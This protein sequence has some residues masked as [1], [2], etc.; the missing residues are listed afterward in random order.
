[1][2]TDKKDNHWKKDFPV[3]QLEST[4]VSRRDFA[5]FL[6]LV[7]GGLAVGS[8][9]VAIKANFFPPDKIVGEHFVCKKH[10]LPVGGTRSFVIN[11]STIPYILIR[12]ENDEF[13][14]YEQKCTHLSC[15]VFYKPG[16]G[17]IECPCHNGLF[18][19]FT[20]EVLAGP[21]PRPLS[22][23]AVVIK[24]EEVYVKD[25]K[26]DNDNPETNRQFRS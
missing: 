17:K 19:A 21:P 8:G 11:G 6:C 12:M 10:E 24:G 1:M 22:R 4:Q 13:R 16:S 2:A 25:F 20:D 18:D 9:Y 15:A 5:K 3:Y 26:P 23:L 7:S 14:A